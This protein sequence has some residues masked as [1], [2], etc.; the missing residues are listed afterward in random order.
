MKFTFMLITSLILIAWQSLPKHFCTYWNS[1]VS[2]LYEFVLV[3]RLLCT[4]PLFLSILI[5]SWSL[6]YQ[7]FQ[8]HHFTKRP[9]II[10][11][12][13]QFL[14]GGIH[15]WMIV[16]HIGEIANEYKYYLQ[17]IFC[18]VII[19]SSGHSSIEKQTTKHHTTTVVK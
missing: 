11:Q 6:G 14:H 8:P 15:V 9:V 17:G 12:K 7:V 13:V 1:N 4:F 2:I 10:A 16:D 5:N 3:N 18:R 19:H